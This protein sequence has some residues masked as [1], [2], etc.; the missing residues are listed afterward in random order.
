MLQHDYSKKS[1]Q[2]YSDSKMVCDT[3]PSE[4]LIDL[5]SKLGQLLKVI[6]FSM[7][8]KLFPQCKQND[9]KYQVQKL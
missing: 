8:A 6:Y 7:L 4:E 3:L 1:G 2:G 5:F 9:V